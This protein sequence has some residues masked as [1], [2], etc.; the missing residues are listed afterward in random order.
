MATATLTNTAVKM[1]PM[2][3]N[4][5]MEIL[6]VDLREPLSDAAC[7]EIRLALNET[8]VI[9]FRNQKIG[10]EHQLAFARRF[11][12]VQP[13]EF[14]ETVSGFPEVGII[15]KDP[16]QTRNV[17]GQWHS[18]HSFDPV[19]PLGSV[20]YAHELPDKGGDTMF[21]NMAAVYDQLSDGLKKTVESLR[22]VHS[23]KN[24]AYSD[25][26]AE[27]QADADLMKRFNE[28]AHREHSHPMV[29]RHPDTGRKVLFINA[30]YTA[31]ID[32]WSEEES[33]PLLDYL[34]RLAYRPENTCRF[35]WEPGALAM[36]DNRTANHYALNDYHGHRRLMHRCMVLGSPWK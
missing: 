16:D 33:R 10:P 17:G 23:K 28:L 24:A 20:L 19:P 12:T 32:G 6:D 21:A 14:L 1:R 31:R 4:T 22:V 13:V 36:W 26:R 18:D 3:A 8:G 15:R 30:N 25:K 7:R 5:G 34:F 9:F 35:R 11:G 2:S 29:A 27:R